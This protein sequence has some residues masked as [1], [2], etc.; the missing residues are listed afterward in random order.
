MKTTHEPLD[1]RA[2]RDAFLRFFCSV[3]EGYERYLVVPDMDFLISGNEWFDS[4]RFLAAAPQDK[5]PFLGSLVTT[6]LFQSFIQRRTEASDLHCMLF[7][8]CQTE[9]LSSRD[10]YGRLGMGEHGFKLTAE[11]ENRGIAYD[12]L[13]DQCASESNNMMTL[14][15]LESNNLNNSVVEE[16]HIQSFGHNNLSFSETDTFMTVTT[17]QGSKMQ[18]SFAS[19]NTTLNSSFQGLTTGNTVRDIVTYP[20]ADN[21]P[22]NIRFVYCVDG[23]P[24]F[25]HKLNSTLFL[26]L[27]P[28]TL[29]SDMSE[30]PVAI[31]TRSDREIDEA[32]RRR[33]ITTSDGSGF[34]KQRRCLWQ[35]PKL[36]VSHS[37]FYFHFLVCLN[38]L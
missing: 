1:D 37:Q 14:D 11:L 36:L 5:A 26:P 3:L 16:D 10:P 19:I 28:D 24:C 2:V 38:Y 22:Q 33:K 9:F 21:L 31:L 20:S 13:V 7:D 4:Q 8:D 23:H 35:L 29:L 34:N 25:P 30:M 18:T 17:A 12:L 6:Q 32:H 27:E 15:V